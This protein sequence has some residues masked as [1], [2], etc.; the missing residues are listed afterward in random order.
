MSEELTIGALTPET[1]DAFAALVERHNGIF[2][3]CWCIYFH[4]DCA[5]R[6]QGYEGNRALKRTLVEKGE[7][8]AALAFDGDRAVAWCEFGTPEELP[9]IHHR[10]DY[11]S[12]GDPLP[13]YRL[14]CLFIDKEYRRRGISPQVLQGA[15]DLIAQAGGGVVEGY[16]QDTTGG[17]RADSVHTFVREPALIAPLGV[18]VFDNK[19]VVSQPPDLIVYTDVDRNQRFDPAVD[20]REVLLTGFQGINHDHSLHS[21][22]VG[23]DGKWMFNSGNTG[24]AFTDRSNKTL[25]ILGPYRPSP[26]GRSS[27]RTTRPSTPASAVTMARVRRGIHGAHESR[28]HQM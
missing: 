7:A 4:P 18:A 13:D 27:F 1:W 21:V 20:T 23:P 11:E 12:R 8:H 16:P 6:G 26:V 17:G 5:E 14:T 2:G 15:L 19:I 25:R 10:K 9:N 24:A 22:T 28:W 3:G